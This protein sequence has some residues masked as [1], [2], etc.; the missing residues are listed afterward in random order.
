MSATQ[1]LRYWLPGGGIGISP[2]YVAASYVERRGGG[3]CPASAGLYRAALHDHCMV[4]RKPPREPNVKAFINFLSV[5]YPAETAWGAIVRAKYS[6]SPSP[7][8]PGAAT[9]EP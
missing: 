9:H 2:S 3:A 7:L 1:S 8:G 5:I 6:A 4:A